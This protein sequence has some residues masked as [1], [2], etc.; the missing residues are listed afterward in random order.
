MNIANAV[1]GQAG[2]AFQE[3]FLDVLA[4][5]YGA[6]VRSVDFVG[7]PEESRI[8]IND[9]VAERTEERIKD[10]IPPGVIDGL[11]RMVLTNAIYFNVAWSH[12]FDQ[13]DTRPHPFHRL[14]GSII[15][16]PMMKAEAEFGYARGAG[17]Q[18]VDLP[19]TGHELSMTVMVPDLG[20][21]RRVR[22]LAGCRARES[23][24]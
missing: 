8:A 14:D 2:Y 1:W 16:V 9:W 7:A 13:R 18:A 6:G 22:R 11:T 23:D 20:R 10:L 5:N 19:Y 17:Y 15:E 21:F 4:E 3:P 12:P 24:H